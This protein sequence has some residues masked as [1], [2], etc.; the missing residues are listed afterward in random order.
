MTATGS[1]PTVSSRQRYRRLLFGSIG[2]GVIA[3]VALRIASY[4]IAA[5]AVYWL[6]IVV[7]LAA[8]RF[9]PVTLFDERD[10]AL[11]RRAS[12]ITLVVMAVVLVLG[13]SGSRTLAALGVYEGSPFVAGALYGYVAMAVVFA[14]ALAWT[15]RGR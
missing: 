9:S 10:D 5:E 1:A 12:Q 8:W 14:L 6:G 4:P 13:A 2:V 3:N 11:E 15:A 7:A